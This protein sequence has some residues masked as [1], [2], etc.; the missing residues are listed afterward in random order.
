MIIHVMN[1]LPKEATSM[2]KG[3]PRGV[4]SGKMEDISKAIKL[5]AVVALEIIGL[6]GHVAK[7]VA[8]IIL[9]EMENPGEKL[10]SEEPPMRSV[11]AGLGRRRSDRSI[12][13]SGARRNG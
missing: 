3:F 1:T 7:D 6:L 12:S 13:R 5:Q 10:E 8:E 4:S 11:Q 2:D 9:D